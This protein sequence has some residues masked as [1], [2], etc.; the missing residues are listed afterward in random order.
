MSKYELINNLGTVCKSGTLSFMDTIPYSSDF[1]M[2]GQFGVG[3]YH[4]FLV[5]DK[6]K[7]VSKNYYENQYIWE[8]S[9][10]E[11]SVQLDTTGEKLKRGTKVILYMKVTTNFI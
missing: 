3:F 8:S 9:S 5:A 7:V 4:A 1:N 6:V 11:F 10:N 2:N